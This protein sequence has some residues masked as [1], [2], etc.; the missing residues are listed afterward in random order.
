VS[1]SSSSAS[2]TLPARSSA[3]AASACAHGIALLLGDARGEPLFLQLKQAEA[4]VLEQYLPH[5][6][7]KN[8]AR[9]VV[10]GQRLMQATP[11]IFLGFLHLDP[12]PDG[13]PPVDFYVRQ[14]RDWKGAG[15]LS[16][17]RPAAM[18]QYGRFCAWAL[19]RAH[20]RTGDRIAISAYLGNGPTF[21]HAIV[22]FAH[23]YAEQNTRDF[24]ALQA[25]V[26]DG[27]VTAQTGV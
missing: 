10:T 2:S 1:C 27:R 19:A 18:A 21:D 17:M 12:G 3:S 22:D 20:A 24:E 8:H 23:V 11:D 6:R 13:G 16:E 7:F 15:D 14:L 5:S 9:R 4:S 26:K 25:A